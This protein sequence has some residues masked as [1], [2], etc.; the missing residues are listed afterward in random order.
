MLTSAARFPC[1]RVVYMS[2]Q[3][4]AD[5]TL[6]YI[7][8]APLRSM[9]EYE[10]CVL[11]ELPRHF[12]TG[13]VL[14]VQYDGF[15]LKADAWDEAF[16]AYDYLGA[17]WPWFADNA[18]G[19]GGFSLRSARLLRACADPALAG[20]EEPEDV[21]ICR[22][23]RAY[24]ENRHG[25]RFGPAEVADRFSIEHVKS[26]PP[27]FGFH[28]LFHLHRAY[29]PQ[30]VPEILA[31]LDESVFRGGNALLWLLALRDDRL[32]EPARLLAQ[33]ITAHQAPGILADHCHAYGLPYEKID[34]MIR[35]LAAG[36]TGTGKARS[37]DA[38]AF[39]KAVAAHRAGK[40]P[41]A[42]ELYG[43][44]VDANPSHADAWNLLGLVQYQDGQFSAAEPNI[45]RAVELS[46]DIGYYW[47]NLGLVLQSLAR[48]AEAERCYRRG[49]H[50]EPDNVE[51]RN[52]LGTLLEHQERLAEAEQCYL[53]ADARRGGHADCLYNLGHV[54]FQQG[55]L[56]GACASYEQALALAPDDPKLLWN[57]ALALLMAGD[58][59]R[60]FAAYEHRWRGSIDAAA[61]HTLPGPQWRGEPLHDKRIVI[62]K[63]QGIGDTLQFAR[64]LPA[65]ASRARQVLFICDAPLERLMRFTFG[66]LAEIRPDTVKVKRKEYDVQCPLVSL[67][68]ALRNSDGKVPLHADTPYLAV[69]PSLRRQWRQRLATLPPG[70]RVGV[71]WAG[72]AN[73]RCDARRS[74]ALEQWLPILSVPGVSF[75]SL[76]KNPDAA[77]RTLMQRHKVTDWMDDAADFMDTAALV[78]ELDLVIGVDTSVIHLAGALGRPTWLLNRHESE[79]RWLRGRQDSPWYP[80]LTIFNQENRDAWAPTLRRVAEALATISA[81]IR[82]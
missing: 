26:A 49:L 70:P 80:T 8:I 74:I 66:H 14:L 33:R 2:D 41:E 45:R 38:Q 69:P 23:F 22:T 58:L 35:T 76:Q 20:S 10:A 79:W 44:I 61:A 64:Y 52:N 43:A 1:T 15:V 25:I 59:A 30:A 48:P 72:Q 55:N 36:A 71:V 3:P 81:G 31:D 82:R 78:S 53:E 27:S 56:A 67:T 12:T 37:P 29:G 46:G 34:R 7:A 19:N 57:H 75:V 54:R 63:E 9:A 51:I 77:A 73:N 11:G 13:H 24:L 50:L 62:Y 65:V 47:G 68:L 42:M 60:G 17:R 18:V 40:L 32:D 6:E 4:P 21:R 28:G 5:S 16:L 39:A